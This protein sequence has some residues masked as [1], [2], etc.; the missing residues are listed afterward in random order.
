MLNIA[1][2]TVLRAS[3]ARIARATTNYLPSR[4]IITL[5]E[6]KYTAHATAK[7][8]GR[9]GHVEGEGLELDM[10]TPKA[11][12]GSGKGSNPEQLFAMGYASCLLGAIQLVANKAGKKEMAKK[13]VVHAS[14]HIGEPTD[15]PGFGL[16][17]DLKVEGVDDE[18][19]KAGHEFCP[20]S[21]ALKHG[22][23]V[24]ISKA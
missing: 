23:V 9:N 22:V 21:R 3:P 10:A 19:L 16:A 13:A 2:R 6:P 14:V 4:S 1:T 24:N 12:G 5:K 11:L 20:Y 7:G 17:V 8:A 15:M 18:V